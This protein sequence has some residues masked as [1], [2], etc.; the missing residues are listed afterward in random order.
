MFFDYRFN[1][2]LD[3]RRNRKDL[4]QDWLRILRQEQI[5]IVAADFFSSARFS[6]SS[7]RI[8]GRMISHFILRSDPAGMVDESLLNVY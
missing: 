5:G 3:S 1:E 6:G 7:A 8:F 2:L 4:P